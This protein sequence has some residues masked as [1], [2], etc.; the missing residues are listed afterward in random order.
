MQGFYINLPIG[1]IVVAIVLL[2]HVPDRTGKSAIKGNA[3]S[4]LHSLDLP[5]FGLF[6]PTTI[7]FLLAL[8]W[9]GT[10]YAWNSSTVIGLFCGS[11]GNLVVFLV[12]EWKRGDSAMIP[13]SMIKQRI[14][15]SACLTM[16]FFFGCL[17]CTTYYLSIYFQAVK[18]VEPTLSGVY[19][20]PS[21]LSQMMFA[22]ISGVGGELSRP[23]PYNSQ[24]MIHSWSTW[25][26][27][28]L[29]RWQQYPDIHWSR[30]D[31]H[32]PTQH[33]RRKM[34]WFPNSCRC[35]QRL[36]YANGKA[37]SHL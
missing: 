19:L 15:W 18:G 7:M 26:L 34:D 10:K 17:M 35:W 25:L 13:I 32:F 8:E 23:L 27:S 2:S 28:T 36:R 21:I 20:L 5:G 37:L 14:V 16:I 3:L 22:I 6:A 11:A 9:G 33:F 1:G 24:L 29:E 30:T 31:E 4:I 12:W